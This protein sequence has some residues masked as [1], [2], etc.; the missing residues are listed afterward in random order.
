VFAKSVVDGFSLPQQSPFVSIN[1]VFMRF[2]PRAAESRREFFRSAG[3]YG[4]AG[5]L[6]VL[7]EESLRRRLANPDRCV[8]E[9]ICNSCAV[10]AECGLPP[11]LSARQS[12]KRGEK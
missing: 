5:A 7:S 3:R 12:S 6:L 4:L 1:E 11:A 2:S 10:F 9:G 8:K